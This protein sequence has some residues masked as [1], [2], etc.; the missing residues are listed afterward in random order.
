[1]RSSAA[2]RSNDA[3]RI[4]AA[5]EAIQKTVARMPLKPALIEQ[6]VADVRR[7]CEP[8]E[9]LSADVRQAPDPA[10]QRELRRLEREAGLPRRQLEARLTEIAKYERAGRPAHQGL[11][12]AKL[13]LVVSLAKRYLP[14]ALSPRDP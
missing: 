5:R 10:A 8:L 7:R 9:R 11:M 1:K 2:A 4:A 12:G 14:S 6:L 13:R 3:R